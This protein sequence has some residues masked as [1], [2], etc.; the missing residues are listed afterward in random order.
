M[1][2][3]TYNNLPLK[4]KRRIELLKEDRGLSYIVNHNRE[5]EQQDIVRAFIKDLKS[6]LS[7]EN[8]VDLIEGIHA[9]EADLNKIEEQFL[10]L[11][12]PNFADFYQDLSPLLLQKYWEQRKSKM[13]EEGTDQLFMDSIFIAIEEEIHIWQEKMS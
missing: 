3:S 9:I 2:E 11:D 12:V 6:L 1:Y 7:L 10:G 5:P 8:A 13:S 4:P